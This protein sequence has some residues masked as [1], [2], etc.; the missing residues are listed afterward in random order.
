MKKTFLA[1]DLGASSG[2][3]ILGTFSNGKLE[4]EEIHRFENSPVEIEEALHWDISAIFAEIKAGIRKAVEK[5]PEISGIA[6]DT[7]GVDYVLL[8]NNGEFARLPYNYRDSRTDGVLDKFFA[9]TMSEKEVYASTGIQKMFFN[10]LPQLIAHNSAHPEDLQDSKLMLMPDALT[11]LLC[12]DVACEYTDASTTQLLDAGKRDWDFK[13]IEKARLPASIFSRIVPPCTQAGL[14]SRQL[15]KE[16]GCSEIPV[17]RA[18]SHD[19]ASAVAAVPA[20]SASGWAYLSCGT[21]ALIGIEADSPCLTIQAMK[22]GYTNEGGLNNKIRILTNIN[23]SWLLQQTRNTWRDAGRDIPFMDMEKMAA[24]SPG[25]KFFI[26]PNDPAFMSPGDMPARIREKCSQSGQGNIPDD[27]TLLRCIY[28]SLAKCFA[29]KL[30]GLEELRG[31]KYT[32]LHIVG[33]GTKDKLLMSLTAK[34]TGIPVLAG[35]VE[36]TAV[37]NLIGQAI[38]SGLVSSLEQGRDIVR[39]S[40]P[41]IEYN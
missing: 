29:D 22:A 26:D 20:S 19:T 6:I 34:A 17:L 35:P 12:G 25:G 4:I 18:G 5:C 1:F 3:G 9:E 31:E 28:D 16:L 21:W 32:R 37:G 8:K 14:L 27:A 23:G 10:T 39:N 33:G 15:Q 30:R 11:Y 13:L 41:V 7:W 24:E 36:A 2:R 40:F 38:A